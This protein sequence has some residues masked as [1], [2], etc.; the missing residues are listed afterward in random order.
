[1]TQEITSPLAGIIAKMA[2]R[3][4][5]GEASRIRKRMDDA[6][7]GMVVLLCDVSGSMTDPISVGSLSKYAYLVIALKDIARFYPKAVIFAFSTLC[8]KSTVGR[9]P[10]PHK[11]TSLGNGTN[12]AGALRTAAKLNPSKT[13]VI[14][15]GLPD[16]ADDCFEAADDMTGAIECIYCGHD[17]DDGAVDFL[18]R[19]AGHTGGAQVTWD[20][21]QELSRV[22]RGLLPSPS[23]K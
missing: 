2:K 20:G 10:D 16:S 11:G 5:V 3:E 4:V 7:P 23:A 9:M 17:G 12:L 21:Y 14:T 19:L 13:I 18:R 22:V 8:R 1:M 15:D 6:E